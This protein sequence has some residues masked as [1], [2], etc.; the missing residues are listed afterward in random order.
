MPSFEATDPGA[1]EP[2]SPEFLRRFLA[3]E[4]AEFFGAAQLD[5]HAAEIE[6]DDVD[7]CERAGR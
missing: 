5:Q 1:R 2:A 6:E 3:H 7:R 4:P